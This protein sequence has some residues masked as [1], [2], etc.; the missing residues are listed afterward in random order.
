MKKH[1]KHNYDDA[2]ILKVSDQKKFVVVFGINFG[3]KSKW[4][5]LKGVQL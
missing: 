3:K 4:K 2:N 1:N 5:M